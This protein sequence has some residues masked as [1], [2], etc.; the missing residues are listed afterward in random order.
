MTLEDK[1]EVCSYASLTWLAYD[2]GSN[3]NSWLRD[4]TPADFSSAVSIAQNL[5]HFRGSHSNH[6]EWASFQRWAWPALPLHGGTHCLRS[7]RLPR[8]WRSLHE[9]SK[10]WFFVFTWPHT[11]LEMSGQGVWEGEA[12]CML[13]PI[14]AQMR[15]LF[16]CLFYCCRYESPISKLL[17]VSKIRMS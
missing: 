1:H 17:K 3:P 14:C 5:H 16:V 2:A 4:G 8:C 13:G 10:K 15:F 11:D 7:E 9:A 6:T 12:K